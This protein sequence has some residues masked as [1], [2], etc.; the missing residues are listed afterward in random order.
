MFHLLSEYKSDDCHLSKELE[1]EK[2]AFRSVYDEFM[3]NMDDI[4]KTRSKY[5]KCMSVLELNET[6]QYLAKTES[7]RQM[8]EKKEE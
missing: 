2:H 4:E 7:R 3:K 5:D 8:L 1:I 6:K